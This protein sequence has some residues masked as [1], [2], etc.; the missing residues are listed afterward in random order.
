LGAGSRQLIIQS[1]LE[2]SPI[3]AL[4]GICGLFVAS[5]S[6][7]F[8][9]PVLPSSLPRVEVIRMSVPVFVF[10]VCAMAITTLIVGIA[11]ALRVRAQ[12]LSESLHDSYRGS[13]TGRAR[14]RLREI[15]MVSQV[16]L[17]VLLLIASGLLLRSYQQVASVN[18]G[19][20]PDHVLSMQLA[21]SRA[22]HGSDHQV[23]EFCNEVVEKVSAIPGVLVTGMVNRLPLAG[24]AQIGA[25][26]IEGGMPVPEPLRNVDWRSVTPDYFKAIGIPWISGRLFD[27]R[28]TDTSKPVAIVD[29]K[30]AR[31][32]WPNEN[33]LGKRI[34]IS[35]LDQPWLEVIGVVGHIRNDRLDVDTRPQV[36]WTYWQ[37]TQD[38]MA[39]VVRTGIK[40]ESVNRDVINAI[41]S[42]DPDQP[43]YDVRTMDQVLDR[44]L[45]Q[46]RLNTTL[47]GAFAALSLLL[48]SV[49]IYGVI[50]FSVGQR[51]R[52]FGIRIALGAK[53]TD[54]VGFVLREAGM[55]VGYGIV[56]GLLA[57]WMLTRL[58]SALLFNVTA[59]DWRAF[60]GA[61]LSLVIV[62]L[63]A[64][65]L[66]ARRA[67]N[68]DPMTI[69]N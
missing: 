56:I 11:P 12:N 54:L 30:F 55:L 18:P 32:A 63:I 67:A 17:A 45:S 14:T 57:A 42:I 24:I 44:S 31:F 10:A 60:V 58:I 4:G 33:P 49:G 51:S 52:E 7:S 40:P 1:L 39:L 69:L 5:S 25:M 47:L 27:E 62:A 6:L 8:L 65:Y 66:P 23:A 61:V 38:R 59:T 35:F 43:V 53:R 46:Q 19:F 48:T 36:Y 21:I 29:E 26:E 9:V 22:K 37:R 68:A 2:V 28:D 13:S 34:R 16:A 64:A 41:H 15:T 20:V 50:T 3:V